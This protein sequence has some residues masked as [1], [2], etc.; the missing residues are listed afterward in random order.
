[1][2]N[3][4][5]NVSDD[6]IEIDLQELIMFLLRKL[7]LL[8]L[9][10][11]VGGALAYAYTRFMI[12]PQYQS[13]TSIYILNKANNTG[14][15]T[16]GELSAGTQLTKDYAQLITSRSVLE[17]VLEDLNLTGSTGA[18][19]GKISV[20]TLTDTRIIQIT[21]T[22]PDPELARDIADSVRA[23]ASVHI[24]NVMD[25]EA[26]NVVDVAN[27]P[28]APS[29]PNKMKN[30]V[31]GAALGVVLCGMILVVLFLLDDTIKTPEDVERYLGLSTLASIPVIGTEE[32]RKSS[33]KASKNSAPSR[34]EAD[35]QQE[36]ELEEVEDL[37][38]DKEDK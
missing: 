19:A 26:V 5:V 18:L 21:V 20:K 36:D 13:N 16:S 9:C 28:K 30:A 27:L 10:G 1:M 12:T 17:G 3:Q 15:I 29:S 38:N 32:S 8:I 6:S 7:W 31:L 37:T 35:F 11:I 4:N 24:K 23:Q 25:I 2:Q 33:K 22:D 14:T 34:Y